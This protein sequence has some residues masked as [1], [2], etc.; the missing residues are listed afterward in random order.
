LKSL[1]GRKVDEVSLLIFRLL[2]RDSPKYLLALQLAQ[3][4]LLQPRRMSIKK[5]R[6]RRRKSQKKRKNL[7]RKSPS[8]LPSKKI[9]TS[10]LTSSDDV[11]ESLS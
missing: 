1:N 5:R 3:L 7:K 6:P 10:T 4:P 2:A 8:L 11:Y 9:L